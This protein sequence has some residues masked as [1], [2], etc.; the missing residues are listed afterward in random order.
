MK[1][2]VFII[3]LIA[4]SVLGLFGCTSFFN[5]TS[6]V[7]SPVKTPLVLKPSDPAKLTPPESAFVPPIADEYIEGQ[8]IVGYKEPGALQDAA[9]YV[10]GTVIGEIE[11]LNA[12][13]IK[14]PGDLPVP[15]AIA[16]I[17]RAAL[18]GELQG[19]RYAEPN[20]IRRMIQPVQTDELIKSLKPMVYNTDADLRQYQWGLD[21][22]NA[23]GA[24]N[25]AQGDGIIVAVI[26]SGVDGTHPDLQGQ[27]I[28]EWYDAWNETW[29]TGDDSS[30]DAWT[31]CPDYPL[32][33]EGA[34]GTHVAGIIA[35]KDDGKGI[36][37]LAPHVQILSVRIFSPDALLDHSCR[38]SY[39]GDFKVAKGIVA[40]VDYGAN[41]LSNSWGGKG[42]S[43]LIKAAIDYAIANGVVFVVAMGN[44]SMDDVEYPAAYPG[45]IAVG[46]TTPKNERADFST[47]GGWISVGAPGTG[48]LSCIPRWW[49]QDGTGDE[50]LYDYWP[51]TSMAT[52]FV[53]ALAALVLERHPSAT[54]Y[55]VKRLIETTATDIE[56]PGFDRESGYGLINAAAAAAVGSLPP[57][58]GYLEIYVKTQSGISTYGSLLGG[59]PLR[60]A[61]VILRKDGID[62]YFGQTDFDG[63]AG[64][65]FPYDPNTGF[66]G[67]GAFYGIEP[68][69]YEVIVGGEDMTWS[70]YYDGWWGRVANRV[71]A[72][73]T[74]AVGSGEFATETLYVNTTLQVTLSWPEDDDLDLGIEVYDPLTGSTVGYYTPKT[75]CPYGTFSGDAQHGGSETFTL[76]DPHYD[77]A[78]YYIVI[79]ATNASG[80]TTPSVEIV[81]NGIPE[82]YGPY[83]AAAGSQYNSSGWPDWWETQYDPIF[84]GLIPLLGVAPGGPLVY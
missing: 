84:G 35:A 73:G 30:W 23:E 61:D 80:T 10:D 72:T 79:D 81:Q 77:Y 41:V 37:G 17:S 14:L 13:L 55:Q 75:G 27:V 7:D 76:T 51:G 28:G 63:Y 39:V 74:V 3:G 15:L 9:R 36:V 82:N 2:K 1:K 29:V 58:G 64:F 44:S 47:M 40:A 22:V 60:Y 12:G 59:V 19:I 4:L 65:G 32:R 48:V 46:A 31:I 6:S 66:W 49:E 67:T 34:H 8:I 26:D 68:G 71:T 42:Y 45:V 33:E 52:P 24:W 56:A 5:P 62:R 53:S 78:I 54:P 83:S 18:T 43:Q 38:Y 25:Y 69:T 16:R 57:D 70:G 11:Q 50:L 20:Y 21:A